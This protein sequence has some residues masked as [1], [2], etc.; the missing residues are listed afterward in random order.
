MQNQMSIHNTGINITT[1]AVSAG[2]ALPVDGSN[3]VS[4]YVRVAASAACYVRLGQGSIP[5][6]V[7]TDLL[8]QPGDAVILAVQGKTHIAAIQV[9]A[10]GVCQVSPLENA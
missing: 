8:V 9:A 6:A 5:T 1:G 3:A 2:A 7:S 4:R 10:A